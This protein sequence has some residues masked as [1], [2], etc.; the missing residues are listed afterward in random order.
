ME[1]R[2][3]LIS[4]PVSVPRHSSSEPENPSTVRTEPD[5][6]SSTSK[7]GSGLLLL[8]VDLGLVALSELVAV[9]TV[10]VVL[11]VGGVRD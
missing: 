5:G 4:R 3:V 10:S 8:E 7:S 2:V 6:S 1:R 11:R 9:S